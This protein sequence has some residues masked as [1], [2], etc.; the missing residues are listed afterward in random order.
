LASDLSLH[1]ANIQTLEQPQQSSIVFW[2]KDYYA[3]LIGWDLD[4]HKLSDY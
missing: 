2:P 3:G 4:V 1:D